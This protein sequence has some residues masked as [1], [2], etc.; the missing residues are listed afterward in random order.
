MKIYLSYIYKNKYQILI[1]L[2]LD[3]LFLKIVQYFKKNL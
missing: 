3:Y 1:L 2:K